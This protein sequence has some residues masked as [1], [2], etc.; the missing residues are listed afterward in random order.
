MRDGKANGRLVICSQ[1]LVGTGDKSRAILTEYRSITRS[2]DNLERR[3][4]IEESERM[5]A[6]ARKPCAQLI[7]PLTR[8]DRYPA[9]SIICRIRCICSLPRLT[10][11][12]QSRQSRQGPLLTKRYPTWDL[13]A[14][15]HPLAEAKSLPCQASSQLHIAAKA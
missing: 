3:T 15:S 10:V 5:P 1:R 9:A 11:D 2:A 7:R 13:L 6:S 8:T 4:A 12:K 14:L